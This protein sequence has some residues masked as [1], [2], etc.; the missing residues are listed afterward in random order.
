[1]RSF[2]QSRQRERV[3]LQPSRASRPATQTTDP[4]APHDPADG[5]TVSELTETEARAVC[6]REGIPLFWPLGEHDNGHAAN[7]L[8]AIA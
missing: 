5:I 6:A 8:H 7:A 3:D 2:F 1:M 4:Y